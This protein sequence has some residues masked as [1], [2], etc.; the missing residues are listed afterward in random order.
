V[1]EAAAKSG[2]ISTAMH[3]LEQGCEVFAIPGSICNPLSAGCH[4]LIAQWATL[5]NEIGDLIDQLPNVTP[6]STVSTVVTAN[7]KLKRPRSLT[8]AEQ[9]LLDAREF[10]RVTFDEIVHR[11]GLTPTEVSSI[12]SA[13]EV[14][15]WYARSL[16]ML[17]SKSSI[18]LILENS[19]PLTT[20]LGACI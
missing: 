3:A 17:I 11:S 5:V 14:R 13:L 4:L 7:R 6:T 10:E 15:G 20:H 2:S 18:R 16:G 12:L 19:C 9:R 8:S 1:V